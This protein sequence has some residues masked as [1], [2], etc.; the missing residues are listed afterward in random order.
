MSTTQELKQSTLALSKSL[1]SS[2]DISFFLKRPG[3][4][5]G[6]CVKYSGPVNHAFPFTIISALAPRDSNSAGFSKVGTSFQFL[7][8]VAFVISAS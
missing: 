6:L 7:T 1:T 3:H 4:L 8:L 2:G 5:L